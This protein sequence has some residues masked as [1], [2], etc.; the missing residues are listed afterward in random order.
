MFH[1]KHSP[2]TRENKNNKAKMV[3]SN[4][5]A[6]YYKQREQKMPNVSRETF[7]KRENK[8]DNIKIRKGTEW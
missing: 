8:R 7:V 2:K 5:I 3:D 6:I 1:V 4:S